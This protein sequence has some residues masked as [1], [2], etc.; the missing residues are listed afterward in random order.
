[1]WFKKQ[2]LPWGDLLRLIKPRIQYCVWNWHLKMFFLFKKCVQINILTFFSFLVEAGGKNY[3]FRH[4]TKANHR[5][6]SD[7]AKFSEQ[8][9]LYLHWHLNRE[10]QTRSH[11]AG[12][13]PLEEDD[14]SSLLVDVK[15]LVYVEYISKCAKEEIDLSPIKLLERRLPMTLVLIPWTFFFF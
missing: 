4:R 1:M 7:L 12:L 15:N 5:D 8:S 10:L 3:P 6:W 9:C 13:S 2:A 14:S 11:Q